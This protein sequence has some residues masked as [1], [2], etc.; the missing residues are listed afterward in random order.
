[1][2]ECNVGDLAPVDLPQSCQLSQRLPRMHL[3]GSITQAHHETL[4]IGSYL[5]AAYSW[6]SN[7]L[8]SF[9]VCVVDDV[10]LIPHVEFKLRN[11]D[12]E[13]EDLWRCCTS[14]YTPIRGNIVV[15]ARDWKFKFESQWAG[16]EVFQTPQNQVS[17]LIAR[18]QVHVIVTSAENE[19]ACELF[20][21]VFRWPQ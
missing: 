16:L 1:M 12:P 8:G 14:H 6:W 11:V 5:D 13:D 4:P 18:Q 10:P 7:E 2:G 15:T 17:G 9:G 21:V 19:Q 20:D 3:N